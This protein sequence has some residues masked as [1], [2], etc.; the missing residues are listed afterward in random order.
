MVDTPNFASILDESPDEVHAPQPIPQGTY[1]CVVAGAPVYDKS[2]KKGT[3]YVEFTLR[4]LSAEADVDE[5]EL[6]DVGGLDGK[7][8][9]A[10]FYLTEDAVYRLDEF[11]THCGL[12]LS[13]GQSRRSRNDAIMNAEVRCFVKHET[14]NDGTRIFARFN[15]S[16]PMN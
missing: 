11:H 16:L 12:D 15:R 2:S 7:T 13:D 6:E 10:T 14:S 3:P 4:P 9:R 5:S 8:L 1:I